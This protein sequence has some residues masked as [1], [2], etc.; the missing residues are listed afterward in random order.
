MFYIY[1]PYLGIGRLKFKPN[2]KIMKTKLFTGFILM[3]L[4]SLSVQAQEGVRFG[5]LG[6]VN[7][8]N[9]NGKDSDGDKLENDL[10]F[11]FHAGVNAML[12]IAPEFYLQPG[13][14]FS[15]KG[16]K[17]NET[18]VKLNVSY[19]EIPLNFLY[20]GE[21]GNGAVLIGFGPYLGFG[22]TGKLKDD[23][24]NSIDV[25]FSN[26]QG[27][28]ETVTMKRFD[29]GANVF[30]GYELSTGIFFQLNTQLGLLG[31]NPETSGSE[32]W[33]N[34]GFGLSAGYRF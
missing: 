6:G 2:S 5:V 29:A 20:R 32:T 17:F 7:F 31:I 19:L 3:F 10:K 4:L 28:S 21:L 26:D 34:T 15:T 8:Q 18:D 16:C 30:A 23:D 22:L 1:A 9:I 14:L 11:G 13:I 24:G 12:G 33:K 27:T 25:E